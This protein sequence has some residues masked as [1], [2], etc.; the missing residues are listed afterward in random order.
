MICIKQIMTRMDTGWVNNNNNK[1]SND[2][3]YIIF[4]TAQPSKRFAIITPTYRI[5]PVVQPYIAHQRTIFEAA[6]LLSP[7]YYREA[8]AVVK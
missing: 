3:F 8:I 2:N 7:G 4:M 1:N 6:S 5:S